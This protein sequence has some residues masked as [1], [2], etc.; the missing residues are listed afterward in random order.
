MLGKIKKVL[1]FCECEGCRE[2]ARRVFTY[3]TGQK[4]KSMNLCDDHAWE[5]YDNPEEILKK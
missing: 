1:G 3:R 2:R 4:F 5:A